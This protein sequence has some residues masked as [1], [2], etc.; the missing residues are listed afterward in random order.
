MSECEFVPEAERD[1]LD[2]SLHGSKGFGPA[3]SEQC[4]DYYSFRFTRG[5]VPSIS[6]RTLARC[7]QKT[8]TAMSNAAAIN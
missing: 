2:I 8:T 4:M 1:L 3:Q 5:S 7:D 6:R